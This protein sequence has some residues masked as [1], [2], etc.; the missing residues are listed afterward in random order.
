MLHSAITPDGFFEDHPI[1]QVVGETRF[2]V[3]ISSL[4]VTPWWNHH[5]NNEGKQTP[6]KHYPLV[7]RHIAIENHHAFLIGKPSI[8][9]RAMA[10]R[11]GNHL[12]NHPSSSKH[13]ER[14]LTPETPHI[15]HF[16]CIQ[17]T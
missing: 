7:N 6:N 10:S 2:S 16:E 11:P 4:W 15:R 5:K 3:I 13:F 9:I 14:F 8:S 17:D 1:Q 12:G